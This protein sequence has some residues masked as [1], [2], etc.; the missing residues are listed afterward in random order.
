[1]SLMMEIMNGKGLIV[2]TEKYGAYV[3]ASIL[4]SYL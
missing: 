1:M 3:T 4:C 2:F